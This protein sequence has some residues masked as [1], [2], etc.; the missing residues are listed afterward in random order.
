MHQSAGSTGRACCCSLARCTRGSVLF[1]ALLSGLPPRARAQQASTPIPLPNPVPVATAVRATPAAPVI[2]GRLD[3]PAWQAAPAITD[4]TQREPHEG[5]PATE[6]TEARVVYTDNALY[7]AIRAFDSHP[8]RIVAHLTRRDQDSPSDWVGIAI[9]SYHDRRTAFVF[10][11]NPAGVKRDL[12]LYDDNNSDDSWD[13]VW[14][15]ATSRDAQGWTAEFRIPFSQ[16]RF[17]A[18]PEHEFG[19]QV[20]R[21]IARLNEE[22]WWRLPPRNQAGV[23]S[24]FGDLAGIDRIAPPRRVEVMP[25]VA[26][27]GSFRAPEVG[28]PFRTGRDE[29]GRVGA[30]LKSGITSNLT[31]SA[32]LNP[33]FGQVEADPAVVN[34]TA[35]ETFFRERRPFFS[36]GLDVFRFPLGLGYGDEAN[37]QLFY[38]RRIGRAPHAS[39]DPR[40]GYAEDVGR[41]TILGAG[42]LSGKT[43]SGWTV[44]LLSALTAKEDAAV[45]DSA[46]ARYRDPV[47]PRTLYSVGRLSRDFRNG[48][49]QIGFF[50]TAVDAG[51]RPTSPTSGPLPTPAA[52]NGA[53][54]SA[55]TPIPSTAGWWEATC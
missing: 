14:E 23:V 30:D 6:R 29:R 46:G 4:L 52:S 15:V 35:F 22:L 39:A 53:T 24:R 27:T 10:L 2:Y 54:A 50:G 19:F 25:Y 21:K 9:D 13:D 47:E 37:E 43:P 1:S 11:V 7:V 16:L 33:D 34:L 5:Q 44:G 12:Y 45:V 20:Y 17:P 31:L 48:L 51:C 38:T 28:N 18:T 55:T 41:T 32:T 8:D 49:T 36:E 26:A 40:G 3:D 42:K